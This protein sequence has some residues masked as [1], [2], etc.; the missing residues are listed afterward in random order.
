MNKIGMEE[1]RPTTDRN[2]VAVLFLAA[3]LTRRDANKRSILIIIFATTVSRD[4]QLMAV[5]EVS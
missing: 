3:D 5:P 4:I 2:L 1:Q